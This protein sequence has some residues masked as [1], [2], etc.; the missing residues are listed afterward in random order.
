MKMRLLLYKERGSEWRAL[1]ERCLG[2]CQKDKILDVGC[3]TGF[4][5]L[6]LAKIGCDV[7]AID[8]NIAMLKEAEK[9]SEELGFS[10][11]ITFMLKDTELV[12]FSDNIFDAVVSRYA[13]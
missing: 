3:G 2:D 7:I 11:K 13:F 4:I 6:L 12:D 5:S 9:I 1:L 10:N 8:N